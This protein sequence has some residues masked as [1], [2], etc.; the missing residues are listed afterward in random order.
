MSK[1]SKKKKY[2]KWLIVI[3][4]LVLV[5][6]LVVLANMWREKKSGTD[7]N[8]PPIP[9][10]VK[11][12]V[13]KP[14]EYKEPGYGSLEMDKIAG[15]K[16]VQPNTGSEQKITL[17]DP[18][19]KVEAVGQ[20]SGPFIED[21]SDEPVVNCLSLVVTN[22]SADTVQIAD[23]LLLVNETEEARFK[24]TNL[25]GGASV[26]VL[27]SNRREYKDG[28]IFTFGDLNAAYLKET[29][30]MED[31]FEIKSEDTKLTVTNISDT[32]YKLVYIYYKY[33]QRGGAYLGGIT[34][35]V[36]VENIGAGKTVEV[37]AG[38]WREGSSRLSMV[39]VAE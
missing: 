38:H 34:Y 23:I 9:G 24:I 20:Y 3:C 5:V 28:D 18:G 17:T 1:N 33:T 13:E 2:I 31:T 6:E 36:P 21:G 12:K 35:R 32:D 37:T 11:V 10:D 30:L 4:A 14:E 26:M 8:L 22:D 39:E 29:S 19:L 16:T 15:F 7:P 25:P 27:E